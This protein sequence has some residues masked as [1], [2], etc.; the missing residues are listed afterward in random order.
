MHPTQL[1]TVPVVVVLLLSQ[2]HGVRGQIPNLWQELSV[3]YGT[4]AASAIGWY[5][6][7]AQDSSNYNEVLQQ[8]QD[9]SRVQPREYNV[10]S[11]MNGILLSS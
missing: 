3:R 10:V 8:L 11:Q 7:L 1:L 5:L 2:Q 4:S 9:P 6:R